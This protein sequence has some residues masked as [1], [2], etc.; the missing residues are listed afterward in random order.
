VRNRPRRSRQHRRLAPGTPTVQSK[1]K[2]R[3]HPT[4]VGHAFGPVVRSAR[5][6]VRRVVGQSVLSCVA[7]AST[8]SSSGSGMSS[9]GGGKGTAAAAPAGYLASG[10][11]GG[12]LLWIEIRDREGD[13][14][15]TRSA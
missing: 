3:Q 7:I 8:H 4:H 2:A 13:S 11:G 15:D 14:V 1:R 6:S 10:G 5:R 12:T 9:G